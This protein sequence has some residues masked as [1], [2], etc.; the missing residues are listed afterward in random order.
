MSQSQSSN[1]NFYRLQFDS[2]I[3]W[4]SAMRIILL[5]AA[6]ITDFFTV[7]SVI[8]CFVK[9][10]LYAIASVCLIILSVGMRII[11]TKLLYSYKYFYNNSY[12]R[13]I[14]AY[15]LGQKLCVNVEIT[16][17]KDVR[18]YNTNEDIG[19]KLLSCNDVE[20]DRYVI[21]L[22]DNAQYV[23]TPDEYMLALITRGKE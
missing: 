17:I 4:R 2:H 9:S 3:P 15:S 1:N 10:P 19:L 14:K 11:S 7:F 21:T 8:D 16:D 6:I 20:Y 22:K 18:R 12:F 23:I 13:I 5:I